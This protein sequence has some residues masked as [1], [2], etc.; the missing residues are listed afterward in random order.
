MILR[1][2]IFLAMVYKLENHVISKY[3]P[4]YNNFKINSKFYKL[5]IDFVYAYCNYLI[6]KNTRFKSMICSYFRFKKSKKITTTRLNAFVSN[7]EPSPTVALNLLI[8][9]RR[10][11]VRFFFLKFL[12]LDLKFIFS[13]DFKRTKTFFYFS[14]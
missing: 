3:N 9:K 10:Q 2:R 7:H 13:K 14:F 1:W 4:R 8:E 5:F 12:L 6:K 11:E